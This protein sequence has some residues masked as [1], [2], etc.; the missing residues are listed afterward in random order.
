[1]KP[2]AHARSL[3]EQAYEAVVDQI[4]DGSLPSGAHLVQGQLAKRLGVSRQPIQ[5][6]MALLKADG[7]VED[8]PGR[9][10][11]VVPLDPALITSRYQIR[12]AL[13]GLAA[14]LA[15][16]RAKKMPE[17]KDRMARRGQ[18]IMKA[19][20]A[21]VRASA[22]KRMVAYDVEFHKFIYDCSGNALLASTCEPHWLHLRRVMSEVV[23]K[24]LP[25]RD[26]WKEHEGILDAILEGNGQK[27]KS[28]AV[29]HVEQAS[30]GLTETMAA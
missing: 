22:T 20:L 21:A 26:I 5:Q 12:A 2:I 28:L 11:L 17:E 4:C 16:V 30:K 6:V 3:T 19:G 8:A 29:K 18:A 13:D 27:A 9:G 10:M 25:P 15:A 7:L 23:K 1:M 24:A 14:Q